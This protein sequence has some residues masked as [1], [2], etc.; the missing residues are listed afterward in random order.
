MPTLE[1]MCEVIASQSNG[2]WTGEKLLKWIDSAKNS[3]ASTLRI[4]EVTATYMALSC[5][6]E[7]EEHM[8]LNF[9]P[10]DGRPFNV[11]SKKAIRAK[12][13]EHGI[14]LINPFK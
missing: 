6:G 9:K 12:I 1:Q 4:S 10:S 7:K 14:D 3:V 13:A 5:G 2:K 8:P 11:T